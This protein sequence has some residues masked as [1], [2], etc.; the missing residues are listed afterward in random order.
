M[1]PGADFKY[2]VSKALDPLQ[3]LSYITAFIVLFSG[4]LI[5]VLED[6]SNIPSMPH[7]LWLALVTMTTVGYGDYY[8]KSWGGEKLN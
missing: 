3:V 2:S 1:P 8:P 6:R 5:Y 7:C 4:T